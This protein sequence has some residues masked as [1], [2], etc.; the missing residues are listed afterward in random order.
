[1]PY[2]RRLPKGGNGKC[3]NEFFHV[4]KVLVNEC[5]TLRGCPCPPPGLPK[6]GGEQEITARFNDYGN[7]ISAIGMKVYTEE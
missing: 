3:T 7:L 2:R 4:G 6:D 5:K 1:M